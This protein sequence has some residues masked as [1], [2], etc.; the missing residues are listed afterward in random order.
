MNLKLLNKEKEEMG[1][2]LLKIEQEKNQFIIELKQSGGLIREQLDS[3]I[4]NI[5]KM[6]VA[7][8]AKEKEL[9]NLLEKY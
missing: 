4:D 6:E 2:N 7:L 1:V 9:Q 3:Q 8:I 5:K